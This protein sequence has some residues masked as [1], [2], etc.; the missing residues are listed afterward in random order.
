VDDNDAV[1]AA[2]PTDGISAD[3]AQRELQDAKA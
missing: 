1:A 2:E 3:T